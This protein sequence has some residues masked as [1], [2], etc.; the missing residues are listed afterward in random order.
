MRLNSNVTLLCVILK[1]FMKHPKYLQL[2]DFLCLLMGHRK[3]NFS[4]NTK[5]SKYVLQKHTEEEANQRANL[6]IR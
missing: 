2:K 5:I 3:R 4:P 6:K 1:T